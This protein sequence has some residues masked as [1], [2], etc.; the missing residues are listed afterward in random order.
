MEQGELF[1]HRGVG[2]RLGRQPQ[3]HVVAMDRIQSLDS[4]R[5]GDRLNPHRPRMGEA[6]PPRLGVVQG[7]VDGQGMRLWC[8]RLR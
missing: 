3:A 8:D 5:E 2:T 6:A 7:P 1:H 4:G